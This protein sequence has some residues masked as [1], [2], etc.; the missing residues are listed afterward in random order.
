[1]KAIRITAVMALVIGCTTVAQ[2]VRSPN[3]RIVYRDLTRPKEIRFPIT[4]PVPQPARVPVQVHPQ[5]DQPSVFI[6]FANDSATE[7]DEKRL[8]AFADAIP[9]GTAVLVVGHSHGQSAVGVADLAT[10]R[11]E[12]VRRWLQGRGQADV[13]TMASW[14]GRIVPFAPNR[15]VHLYVLTHSS[16]AVSIA[17]AKEIKEPNHDSNQVSDGMA[18]HHPAEAGLDHL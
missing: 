17:F 2:P 12:T 15:G 4:P 10:Q 5:A 11:A 14:G 13:H 16:D 9:S 8:A 1:M 18:C 6:E 3:E 7:F